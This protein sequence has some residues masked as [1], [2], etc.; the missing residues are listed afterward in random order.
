ML[1]ADFRVTCGI[2]GCQRSYTNMGTFQN[3]VYNVHYC[4]KDT[5]SDSQ[6]ANHLECN[7]TND[8]ADEI[9]NSDEDGGFYCM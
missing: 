5:T 7:I 6:V 3:H 2:S 9:H 8:V 1:Q 4:K